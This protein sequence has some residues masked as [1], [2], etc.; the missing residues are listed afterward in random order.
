MTLYATLPNKKHGMISRN[1]YE[2]QAKPVR[3]KSFPTGTNSFRMLQP[4]KHDVNATATSYIPVEVVSVKTEPFV[5]IV[6]EGNNI[7]N[8]TRTKEDDLDLSIY[9]EAFF[10]AKANEAIVAGDELTFAFNAE[11]NEI[12][13]QKAVTGDV[14]L[15][16][17]INP[18]DA[19]GF[20]EVHLNIAGKSSQIKS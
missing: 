5:G 10:F 19:D 11:P 12:E 3:V 14:I 20:V 9:T 2:V 8:G 16:V 1:R 18:S 6:L 7:V 17:A 13:V 4:F 15:G